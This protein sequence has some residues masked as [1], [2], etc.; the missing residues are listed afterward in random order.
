MRRS[1]RLQ[2]SLLATA[3]RHRRRRSGEPVPR[4]AWPSSRVRK[5]ADGGHSGAWALPASPES[6]NTDL[7]NQW[8]G[9]C[10]WVP[11]PA[12]KGRPGTTPEFF[13]TLLEEVSRAY[14]Q[15]EGL[16]EPADDID[17]MEDAAKNLEG[18]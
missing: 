2:T 8:L 14:G 4:R 7:R 18:R 13:R 3:G 5:N 11:G 1:E 15:P 17:V 12:L 16:L 10:S 6:K 9:L